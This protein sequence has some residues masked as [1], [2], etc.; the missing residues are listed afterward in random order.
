MGSANAAA[1]RSMASCSGRVEVTRLRSKTGTAPVARTRRAQSERGIETAARAAASAAGTGGA[2]GRAPVE[3]KVPARQSQK[4][5]VVP[6]NRRRAWGRSRATA[7]TKAGLR[8]SPGGAVIASPLNP[9]KPGGSARGEPTVI[10]SAAGGPAAGGAGPGG[11]GRGAPCPPDPTTEALPATSRH[12]AAA[13]PARRARG[14]LARAG[15]AEVAN[16]GV[17]RVA[18]AQLKRPRSRAHGGVGDQV[19][20][21]DRSPRRR[22][23][24]PASRA[25]AGAPAPTGRAASTTPSPSALGRPPAG[26]SKPARG[27]HVHRELV[28][29][30]GHARRH[31]R[32]RP[33]GQ[34]IGAQLVAVDGPGDRHQL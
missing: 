19:E 10:S 21:L 9:K 8:H 31:G 28:E 32:H 22:A 15:D 34:R 27:A 12:S 30:D 33:R 4:L 13:G 3:T 26:P 2:P 16:V 20:R 6:P 14:A 1:A 5:A 17:V 11:P 23:P 18:H 29:G 7:S 25:A 24:R